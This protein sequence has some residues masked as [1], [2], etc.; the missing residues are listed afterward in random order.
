MSLPNAILSCGSLLMKCCLFARTMA[1]IMLSD[2]RVV[3]YDH[4]DDKKSRIHRNRL[5]STPKARSSRTHANAPPASLPHR[6]KQKVNKS[7]STSSRSTGRIKP[8]A[9][10]DRSRV[11][12]SYTAAFTRCKLFANQRRGASHKGTTVNQWS[13]D[14]ILGAI[15]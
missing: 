15:T 1:R 13:E 9:K 10:A 2:G 6:P 7:S 8:K 14:N 12:T 4:P 5:K 3:H 11:P